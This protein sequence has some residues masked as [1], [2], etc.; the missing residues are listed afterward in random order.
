MSIPGTLKPF[1]S[2]EDYLAGEARSDIRH[3]YLDGQVYAMTGASRAHGLIVNAIAY[4]LTPAA[5][6]KGCQLFTSDM[7]LRLEI[8]GK[9][10]FYYPDLLLT[11]NPK[12]NDAYFSRAPCLL[13]EVLSESTA[14][15]DRREKLLAYQT[16]PSLEAYLLVEQDA[17]RVEIYRRDSDWRVEYIEHGDIP[18][19]CLDATL[20]M[21]EIYQDVAESLTAG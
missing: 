16:L 15:T 4:A 13:I 1:L 19:P 9:T 18:L 10:L 20:P 6:R 21:A 5:R 3:E 11:C 8:G 7:K 12:D 17:R 2:V 14:R